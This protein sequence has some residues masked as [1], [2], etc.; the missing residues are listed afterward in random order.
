VQRTVQTPYG[1]FAYDATWIISRALAETSS[2]NATALRDAI[3]RV[4][5]SYSGITGYT[6]LNAAGDRAYAN[7]DFW[8]IRSENGT[9]VKVKTAQFRTDPLSG[10]TVI[11]GPST[12]TAAMRA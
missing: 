9:Y 10:A 8:T 3:P 4:A 11:Q 1:S 6:T 12:S 7:Y 5:S 2:Q